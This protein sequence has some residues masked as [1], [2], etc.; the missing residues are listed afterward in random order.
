MTNNKPAFIATVIVALVAAAVAI[1]AFWKIAQDKQETDLMQ[2]DKNTTYIPTEDISEEMKDAAELLIRN[3][4]TIIKLYYTRGLP[5]EEEPYG[6]R[7]EGGVYFVDSEDYKT[8]DD[9]QRILN[10]T[11]FETE[12]ARIKSDPHGYGPVYLER[13]GRLGISENFAPD[14]E[15]PVNWENPSYEVNAKSDT[16]CVLKVTLLVGETEVTENVTMMKLN[17]EWRLERIIV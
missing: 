14:T 9:V 1:F 8:L 12:A 3:N 13:E 4:Y 17:G 10:E 5:Y 11:F 16:E 15:Y 6:N 2:T 7:P